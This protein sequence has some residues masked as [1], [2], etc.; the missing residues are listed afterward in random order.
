MAFVMG[1]LI[2]LYDNSDFYDLPIY[3]GSVDQNLGFKYLI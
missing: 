1:I 3:C 2:R